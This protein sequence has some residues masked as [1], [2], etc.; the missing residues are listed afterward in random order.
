[1]GLIFGI[2]FNTYSYGKFHVMTQ[3]KQDDS[4][5]GIL[6]ENSSILNR[7]VPTPVSVPEDTSPSQV[8]L[9]WQASHSSRYDFCM[10]VPTQQLQAA[11]VEGCPAR[12]LS[13][14]IPFYSY[15]KKETLKADQSS[16]TLIQ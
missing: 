5:K 11:Q 6:Y 4:P 12:D 2:V 16:S 14:P 1:M 9:G 15:F 7:V 13:S 10:Y 3:K 8:A